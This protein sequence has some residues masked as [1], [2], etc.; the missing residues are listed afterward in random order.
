MEQKEKTV[1]L[2]P[3]LSDL[4]RD[5]G[6]EALHNQ[7]FTEALECFEQLRCHGMED[8]RSAF[9]EVVCLMELHQ[10]REARE[11]CEQLMETASETFADTA[12]MYITLLVQLHEYGEIAK[13]IPV[14]LEGGLSLEQ[15]ERLQSLQSFARKLQQEAPEASMDED[16]ALHAVFQG[17]DAMKQLQALQELRQC[18]KVHAFSFLRTF[19]E[20]DTKHP[21]V[22]SVI[23]HALMDGGIQEEIVV[24]KF[25][26]VMAVVPRE[27]QPAAEGEF[28][29]EVLNLLERRLGMKNPSMYEALSSYWYEMLY[30]F[31]P[32]QPEPAQ[33]SVWAAVLEMVGG[34]RFEGFADAARIAGSYGAEVS[35]VLKAHEVFLCVERSGTLPV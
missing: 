6:F 28:A 2:F 31:F 29:K 21:Y 20:D 14:L 33:P 17:Y 32:F 8:E 4:L 9:A 35:E 23:L 13:V 22:K 12:E 11:R 1:V 10:L 15:A 24:A 27:L 18:G 26:E 34:E 3:N 5:K 30:V 7:D 25:G 19:L 16:E